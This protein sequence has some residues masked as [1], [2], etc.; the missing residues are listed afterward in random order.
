MVI[1]VWV[2]V[3]VVMILHAFRRGWFPS[4]THNHITTATI[5]LVDVFFCW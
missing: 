5:V 1:N 2:V 3:V 4:T